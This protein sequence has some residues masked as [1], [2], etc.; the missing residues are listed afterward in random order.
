MHCDEVRKNLEAYLRSE[1]PEKLMGE[2]AEHL[3]QCTACSRDMTVVKLLES[4]GS[5][6][7]D[8]NS[9]PIIRIANTIM[10][11][12]I[13]D[14]ASEIYVEP[15]KHGIRVRYR[16]DGVL[17]E[18]MQIPKYIHAPLISRIRTMADLDPMETGVIREGCIPVLWKSESKI[19]L[20]VSCSPTKHGDKVVIEIIR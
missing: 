19:T 9:P 2:M 17:H 11:Q 12:A 8:P 16:I 5:S 6:D 1:L 3:S 15:D 18:V 4:I 14:S 7:Q 10:Q 13:R 20:C